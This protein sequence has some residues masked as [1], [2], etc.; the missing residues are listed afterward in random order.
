MLVVE[1]LNVSRDKS[2]SEI[3]IYIELEIRNALVITSFAK[4]VCEV[5][6]FLTEKYFCLENDFQ[7]NSSKFQDD[8]RRW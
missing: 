2:F 1:Y 5:L 7:K 3:I 6:K 4:I 8:E